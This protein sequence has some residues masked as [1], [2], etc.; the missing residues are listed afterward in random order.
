MQ[1]AA[2]LDQG[3][4]TAIEV[5]VLTFEGAFLGQIMLP[6]TGKTVLEFAIEPSNNILPAL[7]APK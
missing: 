5:G 1:R 7:E 6:G 4:I 3:Q 2:R